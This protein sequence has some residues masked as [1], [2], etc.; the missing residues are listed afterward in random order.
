MDMYV[1]LANLIIDGLATD[2]NGA[3]SGKPLR[4]DAGDASRGNR[5]RRRARSKW[6]E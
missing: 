5:R 2:A 1:V 4:P 6:N 3:I